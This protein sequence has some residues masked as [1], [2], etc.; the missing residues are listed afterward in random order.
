LEAFAPNTMD[1]MRRARELLLDGVGVPAVRTEIEGRHV[2]I[3]VRGYSYKE[4][5]AMLTSYV[6]EYRPLLVGVDG[7]AARTLTDGMRPDLIVGDIDSVSDRALRSGAE[8]VVH[9]YR[10]GKA[11]GLNRVEQLGVDHVVFPA[12]G[13]SEDIAMLLAD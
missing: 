7:A 2:L 11:P 1:Y 10:D 8:I 9:A 3:V 5:L 6:R 4:D 12:T 13:T